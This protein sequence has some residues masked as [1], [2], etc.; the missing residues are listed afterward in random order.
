[1]ASQAVKIRTFAILLRSRQQERAYTAFTRHTTLPDF[2]NRPPSRISLHVPKRRYTAAVDSGTF[3]GM[4]LDL[5][6][7]HP[8][9]SYESRATSSKPRRESNTYVVRLS[10]DSFCLAEAFALIREIEQQYGPLEEFW[11]PR[12]S[13]ISQ[14]APFWA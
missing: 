10:S 4:P 14:P 1:M 11:I 6:G 9:Q 5:D 12:V 13:L 3:E 8:G 7:D 2:S